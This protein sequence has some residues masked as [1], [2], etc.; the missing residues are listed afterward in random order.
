MF[1][2]LG[3]YFLK[4]FHTLNKVLPLFLIILQLGETFLAVQ[5]LRYRSKAGGM[6]SSPGQGTN[7]PHAT[8]CGQKVEIK[9]KQNKK[10][11]KMRKRD[12]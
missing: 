11:C 1:E 3:L 7:I 2:V 4:R 8:W 10:A 9:T 6:G 12:S 5:W